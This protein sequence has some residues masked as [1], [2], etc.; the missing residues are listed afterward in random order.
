MFVRDKWYG[1]DRSVYAGRA[2][3]RSIAHSVDRQ[4]IWLADHENVL[5]IKDV[6]FNPTGR[7]F[8]LVGR[9]FEL[10]AGDAVIIIHIAMM[11]HFKLITGGN[12]QSSTLSYDWIANNLY[13][14][15]KAGT[16]VICSCATGE[17][18]D[19]RKSMGTSSPAAQFALNPNM[20]YC[21]Q[22]N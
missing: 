9:K 10:S 7:R 18:I 12:I 22:I 15:S 8:S 20:G 2:L 17:C 16:V 4:P 5:E 6:T 3:V 1:D 21:Q 19:T 11:T 14:V 13:Y